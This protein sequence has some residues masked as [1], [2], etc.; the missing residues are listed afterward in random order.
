[1]RRG[2]RDV[3]QRAIGAE[4]RVLLDDLASVS[5]IDG[6][7]AVVRNGYLPNREILTTVGPVEVQVPKVRDRTRAGV[8]FNSTLAPPYVRRSARVAAALPR[9][10]L[11][12]SLSALPGLP[13]IFNEL[14][15]FRRRVGHYI[16]ATSARGSMSVFSVLPGRWGTPK[17]L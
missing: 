9:L 10:Y 7:R 8:K 11:N 3:L 15:F 14:E 13:R 6:R 12:P 16:G 17:A 1:M 5:L 4:V 2:A